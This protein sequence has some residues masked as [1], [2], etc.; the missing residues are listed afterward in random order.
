VGKKDYYSTWSKAE[1]V[2]TASGKAKN[3]ADVR[4][5]EVD[6]S[7]GEALDLKP[8]PPVDDVALPGETALDMAG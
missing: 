4:R 2:E 3:E 5:V 8:L 7:V 6:M 1:T